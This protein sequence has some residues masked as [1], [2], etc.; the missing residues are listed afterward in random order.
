MGC[1]ELEW[2]SKG[3]MRQ[4]AFSMPIKST[5]FFLVNA[6]ETIPMISQVRLLKQLNLL[7]LENLV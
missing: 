5:M 4:C 7:K 1:M 2:F 3:S 6:N